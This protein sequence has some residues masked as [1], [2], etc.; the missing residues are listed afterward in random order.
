LAWCCVTTTGQHMYSSCAACTSCCNQP[1]R[2]KL[3]PWLSAWCCW[4]GL[5]LCGEWIWVTT[6]R[7]RGA[8]TCCSANLQ[9]QCSVMAAPGCRQ[10][11]LNMVWSRSGHTLGCGAR[12]EACASTSAT[13]GPRQGQ[14]H[15]RLRTQQAAEQWSWMLRWRGWVNA[16]A[17]VTAV[18]STCCSCYFAAPACWLPPIQE[19]QPVLTHGPRP[20]ECTLNVIKQSPGQ[21]TQ[22]SR[23]IMHMLRWEVV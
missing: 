22:G 12:S 10:I 2:E 4:C 18:A 23:Y 3:K 7:R 15:V 20:G 8:T 19:G 5:C 21:H 9:G 13:V 1:L 6:G 14:S 17:V 16:Y 11:C